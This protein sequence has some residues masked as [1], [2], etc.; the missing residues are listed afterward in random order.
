MDGKNPEDLETYNKDSEE[1][2]EIIKKFEFLGTQLR[3]LTEKLS[4]PQNYIN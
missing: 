4:N 1:Y 2:K 3:D